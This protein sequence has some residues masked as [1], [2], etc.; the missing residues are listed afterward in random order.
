MLAVETVAILLLIILPDLIPLPIQFLAVY[1]LKRKTGECVVGCGSTG[2]L[3]VGYAS[4][5]K[6]RNVVWYLCILNRSNIET[7]LVG[8]SLLFRQSAFGFGQRCNY[9]FILFLGAYGS[10]CEPVSSAVYCEQFAAHSI[11]LMHDL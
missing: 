2:Y 11:G 1:D 7:G 10:N 9:S 3:I 8:F 4:R 5:W 6:I